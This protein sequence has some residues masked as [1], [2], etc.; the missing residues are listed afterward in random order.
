MCVIVYSIVTYKCGNW[1]KTKQ[2]ETFLLRKLLFNLPI[3]VLY[4]SFDNL[5]RKSVKDF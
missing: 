3:N 2:L 5:T 4:V 1:C